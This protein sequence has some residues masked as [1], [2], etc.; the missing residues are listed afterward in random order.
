MPFS[1]GSDRPSLDLVERR[2]GA[3]VLAQLQRLGA[4]LEVEEAVADAAE[5]LDVDAA[6][7]H[8]AAAVGQQ[9]GLDLV[10]RAAAMT[11][12]WRE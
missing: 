7:E 3:L 5:G 2:G 4:E 8:R 10:G 12:S 6:A 11:A 1:P 9:A